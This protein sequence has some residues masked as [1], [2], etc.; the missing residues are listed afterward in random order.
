MTEDDHKD[1]KVKALVERDPSQPLDQFVD[2]ATAAQLERWFGLPSFTQVEEGEVE[3]VVED[4]EVAAVR[5]RRKRIAQEIDPVLLAAIEQRHIPRDDLIKFT[6]TIELRDKTI[7]LFDPSYMESRGAIADERIYDQPG[8]IQE[9][10]QENTPQALLRD[11]HRLEIDFDQPRDEFTSMEDEVPPEPLLVDIAK[12]IDE[13]MSMRFGFEPLV[14]LDVSHLLDDTRNEIN[15][16]W[17]DIANS[18]HLYNRRV[19]E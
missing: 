11:L 14:A 6:A 12:K 17:V 7:A 1:P 2:A 5:E 13:T 3:L 18:G 19:S 8:D 15:K 16:S 4:P 9:A 10:L